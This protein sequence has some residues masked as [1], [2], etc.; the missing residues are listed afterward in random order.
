MIAVLRRVL[1][2]ACLAVTLLPAEASH[3]Q[4]VAQS[5]LQVFVEPEAHTSPVLSLIRSARHDI[6]LEV[7]LLTSRPI[8]AA[9]ARAHAQGVDVRVLLEQRPY[10][11]GRY[12][13]LGYAALRLAGLNVR[14][15]NEAAF[16]YTHEKAMV[17][18]GRAAGIFTFNLTSS[19]M[20]RNREFGVIDDS[21]R[22][23][24]ALAAIFDADWRRN[25]PSLTDP[26][27][28]VS[29]V[30]SRADL[31][32]LIDSARSTLDLY[33]EEVNDGEVEAHL[34]RAAGRHVHVR[35]ITSQTS[36][37]VQSLRHAGIAVGIVPQPYI[38]AK[39]IVADRRRVFV[40]SENLSGTSLDR[41]REIGLL[42]SDRTLA[43]TIESTFQHDWPGS[44]S[45][46]P[47]SGGYHTSGSLRIRIRVTPDTV[48]RG[49]SF[50]IS[51]R[52]NPGAQCRVQL[53]YPDGYVSRARVLL[54]E[55]VAG[56]DGAVSWST[57]IYSHVSGISTASV[58]CT[59]N[60]HSGSATA[61]FTISG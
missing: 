41:N 11:A 48:G 40:G 55:R 60:G 1:L 12:A 52:V 58:T 10:G 53:T 47:P 15:A 34:R 51:A 42:S 18:D 45:V 59:L 16:T 37:G 22:D 43:A 19:G 3:A 33:A 8:I 20:L 31:E 46:A 17:I 27:L 14:W 32:R 23:A 4:P 2:A 38:H 9:L 49:G 21:A 28:V 29:P 35:L 50:E 57:H 26:R 24:A 54:S 5:S 13:Q 30:N 6:R 61:H 44:P 36:A 7:Y 39:A 25:R 56:A